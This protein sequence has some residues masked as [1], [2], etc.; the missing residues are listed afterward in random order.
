MSRAREIREILAARRRELGISQEQLGRRLGCTQS[1]ISD[2]ESPMPV[3]ADLD[4]LIRWASAL[5]VTLLAHV[6]PHRLSRF[7]RRDP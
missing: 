7:P 2:L 3:P 4:F 6:V 5:E 1:K